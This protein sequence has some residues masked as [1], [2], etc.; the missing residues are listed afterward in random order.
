MNELEKTIYGIAR[1]VSEIHGALPYL[2]SKEDVSEAVEEHL[3]S[4]AHAK[5]FNNR[6][7][8]KA[9][10]AVVGLIIAVAGAI[11]AT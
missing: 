6:N 9:V 3:K 8:A 10:A 11:A 2:A 7:I 5:V 1:E 4:K